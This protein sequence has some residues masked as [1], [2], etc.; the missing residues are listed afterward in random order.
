MRFKMKK[1]VFSLIVTFTVLILSNNESIAQC[2][3]GWSTKTVSIPY[4]GC[5]Y[6]IEICYQCLVTH[7]GPVYINKIE[8]V[9]GPCAPSNWGDAIPYLLDYISSAQFVFNDLCLWFTPEPCENENYVYMTYKYYFCFEEY[10]GPDKVRACD[11]DNYCE[12]R[13]KY[14]EKNG[15]IERFIDDIKIVGIIPSHKECPEYGW[16]YPDNCFRV[17]TPCNP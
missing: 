15:I 5:V 11:T 1:I 6:Q 7:P 4:A 17:S 2:P 14:C 10:D 3:P 8:R 13:Y 12:V 9:V 16:H